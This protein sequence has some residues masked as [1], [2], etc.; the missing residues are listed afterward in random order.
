MMVPV[1]RTEMGQEPIYPWKICIASLFNYLGFNP[2]KVRVIC[3]S[4]TLQDLT[5]IDTP[6]R[7]HKRDGLIL[8]RTFAASN[9]CY[10]SF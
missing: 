5:Y 2:Q 10:G 9:S 6:V 1:G 8:K 7:R 4:I 3:G